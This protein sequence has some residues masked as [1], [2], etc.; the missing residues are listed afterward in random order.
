M[1]LSIEFKRSF[2]NLFVVA[3]LLLHVAAFVLGYVLL[4]A[5][6]KESVVTASLLAESVYTVYTQF[7]LLFFSPLFVYTI[8]ND[9]GIKV[10][11]FYKTL[12]FT[13]L[14]FFIQKLLFITI[15]SAIGVLISSILIYAPYGQITMIPLFFFKTFSVVEFY[16]IISLF[17]ALV[18]GKFLIAFFTEVILWIV[19]ILV[20]NFSPS[21]QYFAYYDATSQDYKTF[22]HFLSGGALTKNVIF[23]ILDSCKFNTSVLV[24]V[25]ILLFLDKKR[26]LKHG[27]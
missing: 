21:M 15:Y 17:L 4:V 5:L 27:I 23:V 11:M 20:A 9:Y 26:W 14:T 25:L 18:S 3:F 12:N 24:V 19:G 2:H 16:G 8:S 22:I 6:D 10:I 13:Q 1:Y 7:G